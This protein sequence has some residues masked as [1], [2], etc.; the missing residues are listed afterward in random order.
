VNRRISR[1]EYE[2]RYGPPPA[3]A[4]QD[5]AGNFLAETAFDEAYARH[6]VRGLSHED[7]VRA[8]RDEVY[9]RPRNP[10]VGPQGPQ[11][12]AAVQW[13]KRRMA[14]NSKGAQPPA[15]P[16]VSPIVM[17]PGP[18]KAGALRLA[19]DRLPGL[20]AAVLSGAGVATG[21][22]LSLADQGAVQP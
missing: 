17:P 6:A 5:V 2:R 11:N 7:A 8:A 21:S 15:A 19:G 18:T 4:V 9:A 3:D 13:Y 12:V 1:E 10:N 14:P 16:P 20:L 22:W